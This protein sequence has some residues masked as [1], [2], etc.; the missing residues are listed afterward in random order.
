MPLRLSN[1]AALRLDEHVLGGGELPWRISLKAAET[2]TRR[3]DDWELPATL[4]PYLSYFIN[5]V[6]PLLLQRGPTD[7]PDHMAL[8]VGRYGQPLANQGVRKRIKAVTSAAFGREILPHSFRH[9]VATSFA[10]RNPHRP[11]DAAALL[12]H[13][14]ARTTEEHYIRASRQLAHAKLHEIV[15]V[16]L[17]RSQPAN[18]GRG[19]EQE[20]EEEGEDQFHGVDCVHSSAQTITIDTLVGKEEPGD[21]G[22]GSAAAQHCVPRFQGLP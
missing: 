7:G 1:F 15:E 19:Q 20:V 21:H 10:L 4:S 16:R 5:A 14:G 6:R 12:G 8:W 2:K 17:R 11:R 22:E 13:A 3:D 18:R 9:S